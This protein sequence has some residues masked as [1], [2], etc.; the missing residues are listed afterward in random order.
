MVAISTACAGGFVP[1]RM[2]S[3][4]VTTCTSVSPACRSAT[5]LLSMVVNS[6]MSACKVEH[7]MP[8]AAIS[9]HAATATTARPM[10]PRAAAGGFCASVETALG[11]AK[12]PVPGVP[13]PP[14]TSS[15]T[16][17]MA[18]AQAG[19]CP[20]A[21]MA[22][23]RPSKNPVD[24]A[25]ARALRAAVPADAPSCRLTSNPYTSPPN[26]LT[27]ESHVVGM[28]SGNLLVGLASFRR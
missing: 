22:V 17:T 11:L 2:T 19:A 25:M 27:V 14:A 4:S 16:P 20:C 12:D 9:A 13:D 26:A 1:K 3:T 7:P 15:M 8:M 10:H 18:F 23:I 5:I 28:L 24:A 21:K 6:G